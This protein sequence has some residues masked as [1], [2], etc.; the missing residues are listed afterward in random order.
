MCNWEALVRSECRVLSVGV[1]T[2]VTFEQKLGQKKGCD[3]FAIDPSVSSLPKQLCGHRGVWRTQWLLQRVAA[4]VLEYA[5]A[6]HCAVQCP[7]YRETAHNH[8]AA[9][10]NAAP[11]FASSVW[12]SQGQG[13]S[14][15][16]KWRR[17]LPPQNGDCGRSM[18]SHERRDGLGSG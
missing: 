16:S 8:V 7:L 17:P 9:Q 11:E 14:T 3:V 10:G 2:D 13:R 5:S 18:R 15:S 4:S 12:A 6:Q 1:R